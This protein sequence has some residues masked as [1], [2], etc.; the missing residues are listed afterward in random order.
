M[1]LTQEEAE[2]F[3]KLV[4]EMSAAD[5]EHDWGA[6]VLIGHVDTTDRVS[7]MSG[8][9]EDKMTLSEVQAMTDLLSS[10]VLEKMRSIMG[11]DG[12]RPIIESTFPADGA[13]GVAKNA[14]VSVTFSEQ[15]LSGTVDQTSI[16]LVTAGG[17]A[18]TPATVSV[19][20]GIKGITAE[21]T[22]DGPLTGATTYKFRVT[23]DVTDLA[24]NHLLAEYTS[25]TG[26]TTVA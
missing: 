26:F 14:T 2:A 22:L 16:K 3:V 12:T 25:A 13:T 1:G 4:H 9:I 10:P 7:I 19:S 21:L 23:T 8:I 24:G 17:G 18:A 5:S 11:A 20:A 6:K 15:V